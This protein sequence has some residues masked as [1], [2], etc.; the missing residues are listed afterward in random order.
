MKKIHMVGVGGAGM[1]PLA[2]VLHVSGHTVTG[3][4]KACSAE[5]KRL[6]SLG[7]KIQYD[8]SPQLV[9]EA[10]LLV[11][12]SAVRDDNLERVYA[13]NK[14]I[15]VM[16]RAEVLGDIMKKYFSVC[17]AGTHGKTTTT[18][19][20][21]SIFSDADA[22]PTVLVGGMLRNTGAHAIVGKSRLLIAEADE[23]D[24]SFLA[25]NPSM[26]VITNIEADHLDCYKDFEDIKDTFIRFTEKVPFY[27]AVV[28]CVDDPVV[29][30]IIPQISRTVIT[31]GTDKS[32]FYRAENIQYKDA[33][34]TFNLFI[35]NVFTESITI[36][37]PGAHNL[38]NSLASIAVAVEMGIG[39]EKIKKTLAGFQGVK[40]RYDILNTGSSSV[41][42]I[43]DY[44]H[45]PGE[46]KATL[47][48]AAHGN[49]NRIIAVF[50]PHLYSRTRD[51]ARGFASS[52]C[53]ADQ[54]VITDIFKAREKPLDGISSQLIIDHIDSL[55]HKKAHY[56][57][58]TAIITKLNA[59][60]GAGDAVVFM[61]AGDIWQIAAQFAEELKRG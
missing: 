15:P 8:H 2:E 17:I 54:V 56:V 59:C 50:Q 41:T 3:S 40:R 51:F 48:A 12:S 21:G 26:A 49:Y 47:N 57:E 23:Y 34:S 11:Y 30:G 9:K 14:G 35:N 10:E 42:V 33:A 58:K 24:R 36:N 46:I 22:S 45:H 39:I 20:A 52:L 55:G 25:M 37:I 4:D 43:D 19:L 60:V 7:I 1:C 61:G 38:R 18:S 44:A 16:R 5:T 28:A 29:R 6:A 53:L 32:A 13:V 31:Y 27:G